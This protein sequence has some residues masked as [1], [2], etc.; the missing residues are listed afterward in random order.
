MMMKKTFKRTVTQ[1]L[2]ILMLFPMLPAN[3]PAEEEGWQTIT[4][5]PIR[6]V[7]AYTVNFIHGEDVFSQLI[8]EGGMLETL[9]DNPFLEGF[10][11][12]E[13]NTEPDGSGTPVSQDM[14]ITADTDAYAIF[15][16]PSV[17]TLTVICWYHD[18]TTHED[19]VFSEPI[20]EIEAQD[21]PCAIIPPTSV[22]VTEQVDPNDPIYYPVEYSLQITSAD[23]AAAQDYAAMKSLQYVPYTATY[24]DG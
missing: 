8:A 24:D 11:F 6:G 10:C 7:T 2:C 19:V 1:I 16:E 3:M 22:E 17:Y 15:E 13:W 20:Y 14:E 9:P 4:S 5:D 21:V 23:L 12:V 18:P